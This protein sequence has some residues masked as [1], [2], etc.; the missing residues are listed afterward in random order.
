MNWAKGK[1]LYKK[2]RIPKIGFRRFFDQNIWIISPI[3]GK[4]I[5]KRLPTAITQ[6]AK[7]AIIICQNIFIPPPYLY[8]STLC[9]FFQ[10]SQNKK[11]ETRAA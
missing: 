7:K 2:R 6:T 9:M 4:A 10:Y 11:F 8:F 5:A 3:H 1:I